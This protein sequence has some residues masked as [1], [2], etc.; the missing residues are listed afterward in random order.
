VNGV[1]REVEAT[2][3][4]DPA[5]WERLFARLS[6]A[7]ICLVPIAGTPTGWVARFRSCGC[8][9]WPRAPS[10]DEPLPV[11]FLFF[12]P[13]LHA[14]RGVAVELGANGEPQ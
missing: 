1:T 14:G 3:E 10:P 7:V 9:R 11:D 12:E 4:I 2:A 13:L 8:G 6:R 5:E